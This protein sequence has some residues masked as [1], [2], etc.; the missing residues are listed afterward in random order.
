MTPTRSIH[1]I[2]GTLP[3]AP[4]GWAYT[5]NLSGTQTI[6]LHATAVVDTATNVDNPRSGISGATPVVFTQKLHATAKLETV[7]YHDKA[8]RVR[9]IADT[10][11]VCITIL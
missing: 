1:G 10:P 6:V 8:Y 9:T 7:I 3:P 5:G 11:R 4:P 2:T